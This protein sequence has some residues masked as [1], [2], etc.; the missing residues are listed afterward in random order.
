MG[1]IENG[2]W[3]LKPNLYPTIQQKLAKW[4]W[5]VGWGVTLTGEGGC[6]VDGMCPPRWLMGFLLSIK[7]EIL[8]K[9]HADILEAYFDDT[10]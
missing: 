10:E 5:L 6:L 1:E 7:H 2:R 4:G 9:S 3:C 8:F